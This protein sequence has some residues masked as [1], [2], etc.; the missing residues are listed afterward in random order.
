LISHVAVD[1]LLPPSGGVFYFVVT[2]RNICGEGSAGVD[3]LGVERT[4]GWTS[5]PNDSEDYDGDGVLDLSDNCPGIV[6]SGQ[7]DA[8]LDFA[9]D[10]CDRCP[11][12]PTK[13]DPGYCGCAVPDDDN[14][15]DGLP[16]CVDNCPAVSNPVQTD[17]DGDGIGDPCDPVP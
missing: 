8:D 11:S 15:G 17:S 7:E 1:P 14:D 10:P 4:D 5:C 9:G 12:D 3:S 2:G 16:D 13:T 6:N